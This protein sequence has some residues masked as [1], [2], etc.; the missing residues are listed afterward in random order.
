MHERLA[1]FPTQLALTILWILL[2][3]PTIL[4]WHSS[5]LWIG[6]ISVYA[7]VISHFTAHIAWKAERAAE[8]QD[9]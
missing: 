9:Q 1:A 5:I 2:T 8:H 3:I 6:L 7:I 4:W